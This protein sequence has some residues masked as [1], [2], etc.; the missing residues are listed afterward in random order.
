MMSN[1]Q[2]C[3]LIWLFCSKVANGLINR[4][5]KHAMRINYNSDNEET[6]D[7]LCKEMGL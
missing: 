6:L 1:F 3:S 5:T 2:Y 4:T 7:A